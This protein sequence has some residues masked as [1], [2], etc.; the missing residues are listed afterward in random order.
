MDIAQTD[1]QQTRLRT[2]LTIAA[3]VNSIS[4]G[5]LRQVQVRLLDL[6]QDHKEQEQPAHRRLA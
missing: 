2:V 1:D 4:P 6:D 5:P 3:R